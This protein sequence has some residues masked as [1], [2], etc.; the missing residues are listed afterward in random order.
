L[1]VSSPNATLPMVYSPFTLQPAMKIGIIVSY[2]ANQTLTMLG[3]YTGMIDW[4]AV[5]V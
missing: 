4:Q 1:T 5:C 3:D 2:S